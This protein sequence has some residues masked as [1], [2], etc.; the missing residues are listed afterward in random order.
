M[1]RPKKIVKLRTNYLKNRKM[2]NRL[3]LMNM[4][5]NSHPSSSKLKGGRRWTPESKREK[6]R[7]KRTSR[8]K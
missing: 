5:E 2:K 6:K 1:K 4:L 8:I 7:S 3:H